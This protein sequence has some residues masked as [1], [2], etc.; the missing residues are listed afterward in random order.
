RRVDSPQT[1]LDAAVASMGAADMFGMMRSLAG[2]LGRVVSAN[3]AGRALDADLIDRAH[4]FEASMTTPVDTELP[5]GV[6]VTAL[7]RAEAL[8]GR[9]LPTSFRRI[10]GEFAD[11]GFG[12]GSGLMSL[13]TMTTTY[14]ELM[15]DPPA[16]R[17]LHWP[18]AMVPLVDVDPG[19]YCLELPSGRVIDWDPQEA[20]EW[21]DA[22]GWASSFSEVA[23][24]LETWLGTWVVSRTPAE[25]RQE[26][27][28]QLRREELRRTRERIAAMTPAEREAVGLPAVGWEAA[29]IDEEDL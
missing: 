11:G 15:A 26:Q 29:Y 19:Y 3:R 21:Q 12:P 16:P 23:P 2:D 6:D 28:K 22:A 10:Y 7:D 24:D 5:G 18:E 20:S 27:M 25:E 8:L 1:E 14:A 4:R 17:G 13:E 9:Q